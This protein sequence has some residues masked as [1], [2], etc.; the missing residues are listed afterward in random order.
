MSRFPAD[1]DYAGDP[2]YRAGCVEH[3]GAQRLYDERIR[4]MNRYK[5]FWNR[6]R[7]IRDLIS[8]WENGMYKLIA[9][10]TRD[11]IGGIYE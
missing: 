7:F 5:R 4:L 6:L 11:K 2:I 1:S 9:C 8:G 3:A 10:F